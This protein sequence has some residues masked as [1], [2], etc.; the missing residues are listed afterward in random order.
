M[1]WYKGHFPTRKTSQG[2]VQHRALT[3][4]DSLTICPDCVRADV[5][6]A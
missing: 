2:G 5:L 3:I 1:N 6:T 4:A